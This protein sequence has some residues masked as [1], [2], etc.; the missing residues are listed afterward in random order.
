MRMRLSRQL[1][2]LYS[3]GFLEW[4]II[5]ISKVHS[6]SLLLTQSYSLRLYDKARWSKYLTKHFFYPAI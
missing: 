2:L 5:V 4:A 6:P 3:V 1:S